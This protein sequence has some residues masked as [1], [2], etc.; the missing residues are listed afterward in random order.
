MAPW[1]ELAA[2]F[3]NRTG[4]FQP[5]NLTVDYSDDGEKTRRPRTEFI[6]MGVVDFL[7]DLDPNECE[8]PIRN[9]KW[10]KQ[11]WRR[12]RTMFFRLFFMNCRF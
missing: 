10:V 4:D 7:H 6:S 2:I 11:N 8:R 3:N 9:G 1:N 5:Q 12:I